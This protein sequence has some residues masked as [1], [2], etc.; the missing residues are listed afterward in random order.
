MMSREGSLVNTN[1][2]FT[3]HDAPN[4]T[5]LH[6][7]G[8]ALISRTLAS[9]CLAVSVSACTMPLSSSPPLPDCPMEDVYAYLSCAEPH[10]RWHYV[11]G[12]TGEG[13]LQHAAKSMSAYCTD[14]PADWLPVLDRVARE[15]ITESRKTIEDKL[16]AAEGEQ[17][18]EKR[19]RLLQKD[20][21]ILVREYNSLK[22][23]TLFSYLLGLYAFHPAYQG[24]NSANENTENCTAFFESP[25]TSGF[26]EDQVQREFFDRYSWYFNP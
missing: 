5:L 17:L 12:E 24:A 25:D 19:L 16:N 1:G 13:E 22:D 6:A 21:K 8:V 26:I 14:A 7:G 3:F 2:T 9:I 18:N 11:E 10:F 15:S 4:R 23:R 20:H